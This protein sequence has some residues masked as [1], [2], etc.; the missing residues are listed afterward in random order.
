[1]ASLYQDVNLGG[2]VKDMLQSKWKEHSH[3]SPEMFS[4]FLSLAPNKEE[5][6]GMRLFL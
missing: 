2:V 6:L 5:K 4:T 3:Q 1:M